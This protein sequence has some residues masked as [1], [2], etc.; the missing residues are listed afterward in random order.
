MSVLPKKL[1]FG[2]MKSRAKA[3]STRVSITPDS[4]TSFNPGQ[5]LT[6]RLPSAGQGVYI[7]TSSLA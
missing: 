2:Q 4:A 6:F 7:D 3:R 1:A 5:N